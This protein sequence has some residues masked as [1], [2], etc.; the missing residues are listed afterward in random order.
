MFAEIKDLLALIISFTTLVM[1]LISK[2]PFYY[3]YI[4]RWYYTQN[5]IFAESSSFHLQ[6]LDQY[7]YYAKNVSLY[8]WTIK[9][10]YFFDPRPTVPVMYIHVFIA[11]LR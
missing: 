7:F 6:E 1:L 8:E 5:E 4:L 2:H 10:N 9:S 11:Y 3:I